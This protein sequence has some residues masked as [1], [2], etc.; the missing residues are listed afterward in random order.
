M[1]FFPKKPALITYVM[2]GDPDLATSEAALEA[3]LDGGA[4]ALEIGMPF[5]DP[6]ADGP[7]IQAAAARALANRTTM[8]DVL[9]LAGRL[10]KRTPVPIILMG[11]VNPI[12]ALGPDRFFAACAEA[13][14]SAVLAAD[15]PADHAELLAGPAAKNGISL[16]L[17]V[18]PTSD[19]GRIEKIA[20]AATGFL[21][22]VSVT[23]TTGVRRALPT[24]LI[25]R[26]QL[27]RSRTTLPLIVGFG[28]QSKEQ[29]S[30]L[31]P[32]VDG[33]VVGSAI[34]ERARSATKVR[35]FVAS[36]GF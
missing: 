12:V 2:A 4:D 23:G 16:P 36:L 21:Y 5:T 8:K 17:L 22:Y 31:A 20:A 26:L 27:V 24:D 29:V 14:V 34:V 28:I 35:D 3:C 18:A 30:A 9:A 13:G 7:T 11:Y 6:V 19:A 1:S 32:H 10:R 33:V 25:A 15:L